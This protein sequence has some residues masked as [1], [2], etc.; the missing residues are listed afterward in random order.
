M[1]SSH[2]LSR[3]AVKCTSLVRFFRNSR[4]VYPGRVVAL[5]GKDTPRLLVNCEIFTE[6]RSSARHEVNVGGVTGISPQEPKQI[7]TVWFK[8]QNMVYSVKS[9]MTQLPL[10]K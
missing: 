2:L 1:N 5:S 9:N 4:C 8:V 7:N 10:H 6:G 3:V